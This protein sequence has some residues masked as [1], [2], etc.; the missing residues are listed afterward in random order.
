MYTKQEII[1]RSHREGKSLRTISRE[2]QINRK[3]VRKYIQ[4]FEASLQSASS[5]ESPPVFDLGY[6][7]SPVTVSCWKSK[8]A[9]A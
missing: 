1:L 9:I 5:D 4:E 6:L 2:L 3:T 7:S 8:P